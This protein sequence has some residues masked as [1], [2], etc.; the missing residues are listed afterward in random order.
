MSENIQR[1]NFNVG[2]RIDNTYLVDKVLGEGTF[3]VVYAVRDNHG[4]KLALKLL[5]LW[6][7]H[8]DIRD[9]LIKRF[10]MEFQTGQIPSDYLV[11]SVASG[12]AYGN[13]YIV[14]ELCSG[15]DLITISEHSRLD[16]RSWHQY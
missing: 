12:F 2:D 9:G 16:L 8:P 7:V 1:C 14:M 5:R 10:D 13:P 15:G 11:H 4:R 3:G 6:E